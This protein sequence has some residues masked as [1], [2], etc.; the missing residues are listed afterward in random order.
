MWVYN[1]PADKLVLFDYRKGRDSSGPR[2]MLEGFTG[3]L[4]TDGFSVYESLFANHPYIMLV[5][6]MAHARRKFHESLKYDKQKALMY[7]KECRFYMHWNSRC[8]R[9]A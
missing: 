5:F 1:A 8:A 3:I 6:C 4:Q 2:E 9:K 7:W